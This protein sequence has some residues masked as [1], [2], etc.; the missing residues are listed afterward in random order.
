MKCEV[1]GMEQG[2]AHIC[3][4]VAP[5]LTPEEAELPPDGLAA[6][7]YL[8]LAFNIVRWDDMAVRRAAR[9]ANSLFYGAL[10]CAVTASIIFFV[11]SLPGILHR[12]D[13][14]FET[15]FLSILLGLLFV[16]V[17]LGAIAIVQI[18][19]CHF[20]ARW[21]LG[22]TGTFVGVIRPLLLGWFVNSLAVIPVV[23]PVAAAIAW[24]FVFALVL[25]EVD[26]IGR[27]RAFLLSVGINAIS[28]ALLY[29]PHQ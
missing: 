11:T 22:A 3:S 18:G 9:D 29:L 5:P 10:L 8:R 17:S 1:C 15:I 7:Y 6:G 4:G 28:L 26:R 20:I 23:G 12:P 2:F 27:L 13:A 19:L 14:N 25:E 24:M 21:F 16:W